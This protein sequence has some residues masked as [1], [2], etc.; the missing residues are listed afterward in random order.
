MVNGVE[1]ETAQRSVIGSALIDGRCAPLLMSELRPDDLSGNCR[2]LFEAIVALKLA[3]QPVDPVTV[4]DKAGQAYKDEIFRLMDETPTAANVG[5]YIRICKEQSRLTRLASLGAELAGAASLDDAREILQSAQAEAVEQRAT[6]TDM[7]AAL[8]AFYDR[9]Q[10]GAHKYIGVG[11]KELDERLTLDLGDVLVLGGYPSDGKTALMLQ[12]CWH[13]AQKYPV[14]IFSFE[15]SADK[16]M[17]RIVTQAV[18]ELHFEDVKRGTMQADDWKRITAESVHISQRNL[19]IVEAAGMTVSDVLGVTLARGFQVIAL[20]YVQLI[21]P[22][23]ARKAGTRQEELAEISKALAVMARRHKIL[24]IELSQ[25]TRP[26]KK[27]DGSTP[28]PTMASL[29]ESGQLEQDADVVALLYR[30]GDG[31]NAARQLFVAKN[32]EGRLGRMGLRFDG[33]RQRF[34]YIPLPTIP[35]ELLAAAEKRKKEKAEGGEQIAMEEVT[36]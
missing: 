18:P 17:D 25:L 26:Q 15:T 12:W 10:Q 20:D 5:A 28:A 11:M 35:R 2:T 9:H 14:G 33:Q 30:T 32:K 13:I 6:V 34:S 29:R 16:L 36:K 27:K 21:A 31:E 7:T 23:S 19:R 24:V 8:A 4:L 22:G 3:G 1:W